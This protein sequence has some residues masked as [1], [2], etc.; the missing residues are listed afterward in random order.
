MSKKT[1][2]DTV[3]REALISNNMTL[4]YYL[5]ILNVIISEL[6]ELNFDFPLNIKEVELPVTSYNAIVVPSDYVDLC[7]VGIAYADKVKFFTK[8]NSLNGIYDYDDGGDKVK[9]LGEPETVNVEIFLNSSDVNSSLSGGFRGGYPGYVGRSDLRYKYIPERSEIQLGGNVGAS[10]IVLWYI[11]DGISITAAN[12]IHPYAIE[13]LKAG[14]EWRYKRNSPRIFNLG[15]VDRAKQHYYNQRIILRER[16]QGISIE[17]II[18]AET[19]AFHSA[20]I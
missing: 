10:K 11:T 16:L 13:C 7:K 6:R 20:I 14:A 2:I 8:D 9:R 15:I 4:H 5:R 3:T 17:D 19:R 18:E 1:T 12:V